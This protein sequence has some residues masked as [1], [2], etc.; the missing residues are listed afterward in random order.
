MV[1]T[2]LTTLLF[3]RVVTTVIH[4]IA[5][6]VWAK[7]DVIISATK[8]PCRRTGMF[9][10]RRKDREEVMD[11]YFKRKEKRKK[12][13]KY[14]K[15]CKKWQWNILSWITGKCRLIKYPSIGLK[16]KR[17]WVTIS[18]HHTCQRL[19]QSYLRNRP[20][21]RRPMCAACITC[22]YRWTHQP[23]RRKHLKSHQ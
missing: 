8:W 9:C 12:Q 10:C 2:V 4:F 21:H 20:C 16:G 22:C 23:G 13:N 19:R 11:M 7:T 15:S 1:R 5:D 17:L 6:L 3:V 18:T 14:L